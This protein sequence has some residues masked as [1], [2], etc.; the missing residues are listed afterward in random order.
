MK[1]MTK[2]FNKNFVKFF[3][4]K[5]DVNKNFV[6]FFNEKNNENFQ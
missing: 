1:K 3:N 5:Y 4:E 6:K 2:N